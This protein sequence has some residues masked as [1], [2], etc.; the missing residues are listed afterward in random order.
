MFLKNIET[1][2]GYSSLGNP[3]ELKKEAE[4]IM[5]E[6]IHPKKDGSRTVI[7][8][9][10]ITGNLPSEKDKTAPTSAPVIPNE[11]KDSKEPASSSYTKAATLALR[12]KLEKVWDAQTS[13]GG[14]SPETAST[15]QCAVTSL[16]VQDLFGGDLVRV[17]NM[18]ESHYFNRLPDGTEVDLTRDQFAVWEPEPAVIRERAYLEKSEWTMKRYEILKS[19]LKAF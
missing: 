11:S 4:I 18:G 19:R 13:A 6:S 7:G 15:G 3:L 1:I 10:G 14:Y 2:Y 9:G 17:I 16:I 12:G 8:K 5:S